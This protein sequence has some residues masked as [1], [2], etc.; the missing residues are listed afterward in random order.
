MCILVCLGFVCVVIYA[1]VLWGLCVLS[2]FEGVLY[3]CLL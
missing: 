3:G 2:R 1:E